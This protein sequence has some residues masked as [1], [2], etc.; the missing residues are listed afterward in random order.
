MAIFPVRSTIGF[1][2]AGSSSFSVDISGNLRVRHGESEIS[3]LTVNDSVT[4]PVGRISTLS[5]CTISDASYGDTNVMQGSRQYWNGGVTQFPGT[6]MITGAGVIL[7]SNALSG[8]RGIETFVM[9]YPVSTLMSFQGTYFALSSTINIQ[10]PI[11]IQQ[12]DLDANNLVSTVNVIGD[13]NV[14]VVCQWL[15]AV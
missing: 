12:V 6:N 14:D 5:T 15:A 11:H 4:A 7:L 8:G 13:L 2:C 10:N 9:P 1:N 3:T